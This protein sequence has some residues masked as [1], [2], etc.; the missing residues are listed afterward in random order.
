MNFVAQGLQSSIGD[1]M[2]F[3]TPKTSS[4]LCTLQESDDLLVLF[5]CCHFKSSLPESC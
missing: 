4:A 5:A 3:V 2:K 1:G